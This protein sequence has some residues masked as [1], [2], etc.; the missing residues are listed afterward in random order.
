M[1]FLK[2]RCISDVNSNTFPHYDVIV[3]RGLAQL[4]APGAVMFQ[5][6]FHL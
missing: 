5:T 2:F 1:S 4:D 3:S 6:L